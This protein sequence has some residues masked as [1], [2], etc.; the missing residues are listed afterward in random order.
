MRDNNIYNK[1]GLISVI[2]HIRMMRDFLIYEF[3]R[4]EERLKFLLEAVQ[5][6]NAP[7]DAHG[8]RYAPNATKKQYPLIKLPTHIAQA[9]RSSEMAQSEGI[10]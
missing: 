3:A 8:K 10:G 1:D 6:F 5:E 9:F 7:V 2:R 4:E